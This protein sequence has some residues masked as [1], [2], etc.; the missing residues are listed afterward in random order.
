MFGLWPD[1]VANPIGT[2]S[3]N[4]INKDSVILH[5]SDVLST[6]MRFS[7]QARNSS[8]FR[9]NWILLEKVKFSS[10]SQARCKEV[11][12]HVSRI[13]FRDTQ[14]IRAGLGRVER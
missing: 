3:S 4:I 6:V 5:V 8:Y 9:F 10:L 12:I 7:F 2:C 1:Q 11:V 14:E 13:T